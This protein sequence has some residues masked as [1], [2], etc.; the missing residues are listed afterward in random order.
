MRKGRQ[1]KLAYGL[2]S[3]TDVITCERMKRTI[4]IHLMTK[5]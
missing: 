1:K 5:Y 3:L 4:S 2:N